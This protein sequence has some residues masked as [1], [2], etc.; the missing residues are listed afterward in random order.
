MRDAHKILVLAAL[1]LLLALPSVPRLLDLSSFYLHPT[2]APEVAQAVQNFS[3]TYGVTISSFALT[4]V[5]YAP[6]GSLT[7]NLTYRYP[8]PVKSCPSIPFTITKD[9][10]SE[11]TDF[12]TE[13][14][15]RGYC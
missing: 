8:S 10:S 14:I 2:Q 13:V 3:E 4:H 11:H 12:A 5:T 7:M 9:S 15:A 1:A 6:D